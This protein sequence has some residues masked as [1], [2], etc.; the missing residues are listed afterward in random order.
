MDTFLARVS[1]SLAAVKRPILEAY[2]LISHAAH[3]AGDELCD[4]VYAPLLLG[5]AVAEFHFSYSMEI[6]ADYD[7]VA[8]A[9]PSQLVMQ[10]VNLRGCCK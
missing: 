6:R 7:C 8:Q 3:A 2:E 10:S 5:P 1:Q 4:S 9:L